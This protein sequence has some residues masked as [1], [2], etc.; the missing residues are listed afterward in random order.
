MDGLGGLVDRLINTVSGF[1]AANP[2][3]ANGLLAVVVVMFIMFLLSDDD[4]YYRRGGRGRDGY[5]DGYEDGYRDSRC[6]W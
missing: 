6:G 3:I 4:Q 1:F 5:R 2:A